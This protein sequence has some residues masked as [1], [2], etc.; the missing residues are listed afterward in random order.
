MFTLRPSS[1]TRAAGVRRAAEMEEIKAVPAE[2]A[3]DKTPAAPFIDEGLPVPEAYEVD[4]VRAML[5]DPF[6]IF[7]YWEL[8]EES[9]RALSLYFSPEEAA[10]FQT[11]LRLFEV[12]GR[13]E[14]YF[15][16]GRR[17]RYWMMVFP[18]REYEFEVGVR[19]PV[20]GYISLIRSNRVRTPRGTVSPEKSEE[21]EYRLSPPE[22]MNVIEASGFAAEQAMDITVAAMPGA[23]VTPDEM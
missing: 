9:L 21:G 16:V 19:S 14:A 11:T 17:G 20:H 8:R 10:A 2:E 12:E 7:I 22:F 4:I 15:P 5:Q 3:G 1:P 6:R 18:E 23:G 13:N